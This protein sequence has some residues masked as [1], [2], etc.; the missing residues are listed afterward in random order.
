MDKPLSPGRLHWACRRGMLEL[1]LLLGGFLESGYE[2]LDPGQRRVF[3]RLLDYPDQQLY[4]MC[5]G[6]RAVADKEVADVIAKIRH[7][8]A[9]EA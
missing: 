3:Q 8:A 9:A 2:Q 6:Q 7:A 5:L 4:E 1:D